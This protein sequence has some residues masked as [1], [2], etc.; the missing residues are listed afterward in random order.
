MTSMELSSL[1]STYPARRKAAGAQRFFNVLVSEVHFG[2]IVDPVLA[3]L[4]RV[5]SPFAAGSYGVTDPSR[6]VDSDCHR[7]SKFEIDRR[8]PSTE[9]NLHLGKFD[10]R[11]RLLTEPLALSWI[12]HELRLCGP[13]VIPIAAKWILLFDNLQAGFR[14]RYEIVEGECK[15]SVCS[16]PCAA[17]HDR[18]SSQGEDDACSGR[19]RRC[20]L[21]VQLASFAQPPAL[22]Y[23]VQHAHF[24]P[25]PW[26]WGDSATGACHA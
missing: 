7:F 22:A 23:A 4:W 21:P 24:R 3:P 6:S 8:R 20:S 17:A 14:A 19:H 5:I 12:G 16:L 26:T 11:S 2:P 1:A 25:P 10:Q 18:R 15:K 9:V 13:T